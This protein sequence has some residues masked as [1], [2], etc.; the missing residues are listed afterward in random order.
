MHELDTILQYADALDAS[1]VHLKSGLRPRFRVAGGLRE[2][3]EVATLSADD[4]GRITTE[5][6]TPE[7]LSYLDSHCE[8][9]FTYGSDIGRFRCAYFS[10]HW[11]PA[12]VYRRIPSHIAT[13]EE[14]GLPDGITQ[15]AHLHRG[16]MLVTGSTGSGK[17]ATMAAILDI[18]NERYHKHI[19]TLEDPI[20]Y[21]HEDRLGVIHQRGLH[22]DFADFGSGIIA[23]MRQD[24]DVL[25][26]GELRDEESI[27]HALTAAETGILVFGTLHTNG[28]AESVNR[29]IDAFPATEQSQVRVQ[30]SE[31]LAG[32]VSQVLVNRAD[33]QGRIPAT[34]VLV[35]TPAVGSLIRDGKTQDIANVIQGG[36][37]RG[38]HTLDDS[39][40]ELVRQQLVT[41]REAACHSRNK[42]RFEESP[43][44]RRG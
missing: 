15:F 23:A 41:T 37:S 26:I 34:E 32:V 27:R 28:A 19:I 3:E 40:A 21:L 7:Q 38:M 20:E 18:I 43:Y 44:K 16:L 4:I 30:L 25:V 17:S 12:A 13:L 14:L 6:M 10:D 33:D 42:G 9:D 8:V 24:P 29:I 35:A 1:D 2:L 5:I 31:S 22:D 11:G 39:L 36:R